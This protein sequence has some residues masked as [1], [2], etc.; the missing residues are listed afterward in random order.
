MNP[1]QVLVNTLVWAGELGIIALGMTLSYAILRFANF[2]HIEFVTMGAYLAWA[3]YRLL[4]LPLLLAAGLSIFATGLLAVAIDLLVFRRLR[5]ASATL[6]MIASVGVSI[7]IRA[8]VQVVF[9][10]QAQS[11][12][13]SWETLPAMLGARFTILQ[14]WIVGVTISSVLFFHFV[15]TL[16]RVGKALRATAEN[17]SLAQARGIDGAR[18]IT[19]MWLISG[20]FAGLG[21]VLLGIETQLRPSIGLSVMLPIFAAATIGGLGSAYGAIAGAFTLSLAQN[22]VLA[23]NF[24]GLFGVGRGWWVPT[25]YKEVVSMAALVITLFVKPSG[26]FA[27]RERPYD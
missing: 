22:A 4:R 13:L 17:F 26:I 7:V 1:A 8:I 12:G 23:I 9:S 6:K 15:M 27:S 25:S 10:G 14:I 19:L 5:A 24:G 2:A 18:M 3:G 11:F 21:G 16:T 20:A